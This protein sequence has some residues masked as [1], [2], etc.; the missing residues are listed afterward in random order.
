MP[1][2]TM[3]ASQ[4]ASF[5]L[6][7]H[8]DD[9]FGVLHQ[10]E[11]DLA[12]GRQVSVAYLT[13]GTRS[14]MSPVRRNRESLRVL[15]ALGVQSDQV[16]FAGEALGIDDGLLLDKLPEASAWLSHRLLYLTG[17]DRV[18]IPAWEGGHP[19]HDALHAV[20]VHSCRSALC[21]TLRQYPLYNARG[22]R[23][24]WFKV[25]SPIPENGDPTRSPIPWK[26]RARHL[27]LMLGYPS[28][29]KSWLGLF[30]F[31]LWHYATSGAQSLQAVTPQRIHERPHDGP[32]YYENRQFS[33]W[34]K[35]NA[36]ITALTHTT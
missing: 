11:Q 5:Y 18:Y 10:I 1:I 30:P 8:Q 16:F 13:A 19:D 20:A 36:A 12:S 7:A 2:E 17:N 29:W 27:K 22:C 25:L 32:L 4:G 33:T 9:E 26:S 21:W 31:T 14:P 23:N 35:V 28:Q 15:S 3:P 6:F 24:P 34:G